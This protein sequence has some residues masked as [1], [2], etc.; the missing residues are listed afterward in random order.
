[1][2]LIAMLLLVLQDAAASTLIL[3][4]CQLWSAGFLTKPG[5]QFVKD[6]EISD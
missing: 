3:K 1:M 2:Q 5:L 6:F 4:H